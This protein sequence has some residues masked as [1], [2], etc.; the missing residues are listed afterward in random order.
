MMAVLDPIK[1]VI[2]NYPE[3]EV[4]YLDVAEQSGERGAGYTERFRFA[5]SC[6]LRERISW[7]NRRRNTSVCSRAMKSV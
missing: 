2:D 1:L 7:R 4:E 3:G 6:I 5:E